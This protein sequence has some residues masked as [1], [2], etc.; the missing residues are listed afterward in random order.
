MYMSKKEQ[1]AI[2]DALPQTEIQAL[3]NKEMNERGLTTKDLRDI[4]GTITMESARRYIKG[5]K[6][7]SDDKLKVLS[8]Y[9]GWDYEKVRMMSIRDRQRTRHG[10][11]FD[12]SRDIDAEAQRFLKA[13]PLL[14]RQQKSEL[15]KLLA[16]YVTLNNKHLG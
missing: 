2:A 6:N 14:T 15:K 9:F 11:L 13:W 4:I 16:Q 8:T 1:D 5:L 7:P 12:A 3:I 10:D